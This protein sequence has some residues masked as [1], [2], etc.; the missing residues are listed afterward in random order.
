MKMINPFK[1]GDKVIFRDDS[2]GYISRVDDTGM[3]VNCYMQYEISADRHHPNFPLFIEDC[4]LIT[5]ED[6][7]SLIVIDKLKR[8]C[9]NEY[10]K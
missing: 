1:V 4:K 6:Y 7:D 2:F 8:E 10:W 5:E 9:V 3:A